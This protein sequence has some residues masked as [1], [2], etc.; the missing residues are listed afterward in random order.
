MPVPS[1]PSNGERRQPVA[2]GDAARD[3]SDQAL[4]PVL[5]TETEEGTGWRLIERAISEGKGFFKHMGFDGFP[6][7]IQLLELAGDDARLDV[8]VAGKEFSAEV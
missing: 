7:R 4:V 5:G 2:L 8:V 3:K 6:L 1:I